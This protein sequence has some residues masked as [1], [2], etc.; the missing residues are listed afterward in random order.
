[1][2]SNIFNVPYRILELLRNYSKFFSIKLD[3]DY[4]NYWENTFVAKY[5]GYF[6]SH[7]YFYLK[8]IQLILK[9]IL[10]YQWRI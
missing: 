1:M 3:R 10:S 9:N 5:S 7:A 2:V 6:L 8:N 4:K